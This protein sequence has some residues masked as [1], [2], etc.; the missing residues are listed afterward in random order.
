MAFWVYILQCADGRYY[1][2]QTDDLERR[3]AEHQTGE[4][5][6]FTARRRP[7]CLAWTESFQTRIEALE[8]EHRIK[9]WSRAKKQALIRGDW[10]SLS[11][12]A[13][14]PSERPST[15][16]GTNGEKE[17]GTGKSRK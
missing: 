2:G 3:V 16:L 7:L 12:F 6:D 13:R 5:C 14:P 15:S 17:I 1:T 11:Y 8:A 4:F 10:A 9:S